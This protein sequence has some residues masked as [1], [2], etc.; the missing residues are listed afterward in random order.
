MNYPAASGR[1]I[2][3]SLETP[4][5]QGIKPKAPQSKMDRG[6]VSGKDFY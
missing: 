4:Q 3:E 5:G 1:G 6:N 2:L